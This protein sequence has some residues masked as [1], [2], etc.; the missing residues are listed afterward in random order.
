MLPRVSYYSMSGRNG[1]MIGP[2]YSRNM[3]LPNNGAN[4]NA[5]YGSSPNS[6]R[7]EDGDYTLQCIY[8]GQVSPIQDQCL[9][10]H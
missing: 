7:V 4:S 1:L 9:V 8:G 6:Y 5:Y 3:V 10:Q 2:A